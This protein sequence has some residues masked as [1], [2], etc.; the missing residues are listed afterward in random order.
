[1]KKTTL[2]EDVLRMKEIYAEKQTQDSQ[3]N[4]GSHAHGSRTATLHCSHSG[5][6]ETSF[7]IS[8]TS[9]VNDYY[10]EIKAKIKVGSNIDSA[11]KESICAFV[12]HL[13]Y[14]HNCYIRTKSG[15]RHTE[16]NLFAK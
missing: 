6:I 12:K 1:M 4:Y 7:D 11:S 2:K 3:S 10:V 5:K 9:C 14:K 16:Y 8:K 13:A 15:W